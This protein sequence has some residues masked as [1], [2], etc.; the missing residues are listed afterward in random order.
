MK[1]QAFASIAVTFTFSQ[2]VSTDVGQ[3]VGILI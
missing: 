3:G 2:T 1:I